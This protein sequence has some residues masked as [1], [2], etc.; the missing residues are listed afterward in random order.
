MIIKE[1]ESIANRE[2]THP[3]ILEWE[4]IDPKKK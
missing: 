1:I 4:F 2:H 3:H